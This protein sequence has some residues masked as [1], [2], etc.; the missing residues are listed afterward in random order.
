[1]RRGRRPEGQP[2]G[3]G[4]GEGGAGEDGC[5]A[6]E[7]Y[8]TM[9]QNT[10]LHITPVEPPLPLRRQI[11]APSTCNSS[12]TTTSESKKSSGSTYGHIERS[13]EREPVADE[14][15]EDE[16]ASD[17]EDGGQECSNAG[18]AVEGDANTRK[19]RR[20]R[21]PNKAKR[22]RFKTF[23]EKLD[24][25]VRA[26]PENFNFEEVSAPASIAADPHLLSQI[27]SR[28]EELAKE[29]RGGPAAAT[30]AGPKEQQQLSVG[31]LFGGASSSNFQAN[32]VESSRWWA[33]PEAVGSA[34]GRGRQQLDVP[35]S[36]SSSQHWED[37]LARGAGRGGSAAERGPTSRG[38]GRGSGRRRVRMSL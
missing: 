28:A 1:M 15:S 38:S 35:A 27:K 14:D 24:A 16:D 25:H 19:E 2:G 37:P 36:S 3:R 32:N 12:D 8:R 20:R 29:Q 13:G 31:Q 30:I 7:H 5:D 26:D 33:G 6:I 4:G 11:S 18:A 10:F 22:E 17:P 23:L 9:N 21:R 34:A